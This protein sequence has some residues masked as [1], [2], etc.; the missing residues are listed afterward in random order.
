MKC[1]YVLKT[2][3]AENVRLVDLLPFTEIHLCS[4]LDHYK[5][6]FLKEKR[7]F[8]RDESLKRKEM[9]NFPRQYT[10]VSKLSFSICKT[11]VYKR[12][13]MINF[14]N[15]QGKLSFFVLTRI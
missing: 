1:F 6:I 13:A 12:K 11:L 7:S 3:Q 8:E 14:L 5:T 15:G 2:I 4:Q 9:V 10:M